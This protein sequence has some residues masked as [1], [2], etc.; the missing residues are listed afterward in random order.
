MEFPIL[1]AY[2]SQR[3]VKFYLLK[4]KVGVTC[5]RSMLEFAHIVREKNCL[6]YIM[7]S[8]VLKSTFVDTLS[9]WIESEHTSLFVKRYVLCKTCV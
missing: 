8:Y 2:C 3:S 1:I 4:G 7:L 5:V 9:P 6:C